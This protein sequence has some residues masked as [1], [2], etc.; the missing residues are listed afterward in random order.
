MQKI[1]ISALFLL[2]LD[3]IY[4]STTSNFYRNLIESIQKEKMEVKLFPAIFCY[5]VLIF[6]LYYFILKSRKNVF[7]AFI[8]GLCIYAVYE[9]TN[10]S[11]LRK[12]SPKAVI[13]DTLWGGILFSLTTY[14]TYRLI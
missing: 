14:F 4:L 3:F 10:Y 2:I 9:L 12:W 7:D 5:I 11:I 8:L 1:I 13:M 6:S